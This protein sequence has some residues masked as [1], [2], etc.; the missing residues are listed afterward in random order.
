[1]Q[2]R[3]ASMFGNIQGIV[4]MFVLEPLDNDTEENFESQVSST[5]T[6]AKDQRLS[7]HLQE[8]SFMNDRTPQA[9]LLLTALDTWKKNKIFGN[10]I[11]SF[12]IDCGKLQEYKKDRLCS[13]HPHNYYVEILTE[14][15][16]VG[17]FITSVIG[18]LFVI[19]IF[20]NFKSLRENNK[21]NLILL[22]AT[23]SLFLETFPIR[24][25]GSIFTTH[26]ATYLVL[27]ASI[28][29]SYN[30]LLRAENFR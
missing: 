17:F 25:T 23:I 29:L 26:N 6:I 7:F 22:A 10:G 14:T 9:R 3:Y 30:K 8:L 13:S 20:K 27:I 16:L 11:K 21:E 2:T 4:G 12:R 28:I 24:P 19:F 1:M 15:G 5:K 18:L